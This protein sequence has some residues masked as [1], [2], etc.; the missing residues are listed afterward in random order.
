MK[1]S[2]KYNSITTNHSNEPIRVLTQKLSYVLLDLICSYLISDNRSIRTKGYANIETLINLI[3]MEDYKTESDIERLD[4]IRFGLDARIRY[5]LVNGAQV[6]DYIFS[7]D[8]NHA[9]NYNINIQEMS[10][11]DVTYVDETVTNLLDSAS[12]AA[13]IHSFDNF[14]KDFDN[15]NS[16]QKKQ[17][18]DAWKEQIATCSTMIRNNRVNKAEEEFV[19]LREGIFEDYAKDTHAYISNSSSR[20]S[21]GMYAMNCLLGGGFE[22]GRVYGFFGLQGE[23]KSI[24]LLNFATQIKD[25][26]KKYKTKDPTKKPA[27]VYL[28]L[29][30]TKR[31]TFTR[32]FSMSTGKGRMIDYDAEDSIKMMRESGLKV[33]DDNPID[34]IIKYKPSNTVTT[35]YLYELADELAE[36]NYEVICYIVDYINVIRSVESFSASEERLRLGAIINEFKTI[37]STMDIPILTAG[38][39][40]REANKK[41]DELRDKGNLNLLGA[42]DRSNLGESMLIL[43]NLDAA[44]IIT[45]SMVKSTNEKYLAI[46]LVKQRYTPNI[47]PLNYSYGVYHP[48]DSIDGIK[49]VNDV[50]AHEPAFLLDLSHKKV[51]CEEDTNV[52]LPDNSK[53]RVPILEG[54]KEEVPQKQNP[55]ALY[56]D[57]TKPLYDVYWRTQPQKINGINNINAMC[58]E[59]QLR[60]KFKRKEFANI[61]SDMIN[62]LNGISR[63]S[64]MYTRLYDP[65]GSKEE[66][67]VHDYRIKYGKEF[68][69]NDF[70]M[71]YSHFMMLKNG[72]MQDTD[73]FI[74]PTKTYTQKEDMSSNGLFVYV[75][76]I[77]QPAYLDYINSINAR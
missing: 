64:D 19:S 43:N 35:A 74:E 4:F 1:I 41:V 42:I 11:K 70:P 23:G 58:P 31:E 38:Q 62:Q 7:N 66:R 49:L 3:N 16:Y 32:L 21:T 22:N 8:V 59:K 18:I 68:T 72:E 9:G 63:Y 39:L 40:N 13:Y 45:P 27:V 26:N 52:Q 67:L 77:D 36:Y 56:D 53:R 10:N 25:F 47:K 15:A 54:Q 14:G 69:T 17:I 20:L 12:F 71:L 55:V 57:G 76:K 5:G 46:K 29:E 65:S 28:T 24:T 44:F 51:E 60:A 2:R 30:N 75:P 73:E 34:I 33:T 48:Y 61:M 37:A 6:R 50:N